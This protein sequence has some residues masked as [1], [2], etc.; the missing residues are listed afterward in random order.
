MAAE[1]DYMANHDVER[2]VT[3]SSAVSILKQKLDWFETRYAK[4]PTKVVCGWATYRRLMIEMMVEAG[5]E[6]RR[7]TYVTFCG[8]PVLVRPDFAGNRVEFR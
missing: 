2:F 5:I 7:G 8:L 6:R 3:S 1:G 4:S